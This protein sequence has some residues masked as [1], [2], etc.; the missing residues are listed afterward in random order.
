MVIIKKINA[1]A[2]YTSNTLAFTSARPS[3]TEIAALVSHLV[4]THSLLLLLL[5]DIITSNPTTLRATS[6]RKQKE[7]FAIHTQ[8]QYVLMQ[9]P[10]W[11]VKETM[12]TLKDNV[13]TSSR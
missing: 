13:P 4:I 9:V 11:I 1:D 5:R 10:T 3:S 6:R 8:Y 7:R 2:H 12:T